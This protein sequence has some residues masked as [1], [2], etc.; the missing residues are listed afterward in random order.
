MQCHVGN[1]KVLQSVGE[2][3]AEEQGTREE[4]VINQ[5]R[6]RVLSSPPPCLVCL[7]EL[8]L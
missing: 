8:E 6:V 4:S 7:F 5:I 3:V 2:H 1:V